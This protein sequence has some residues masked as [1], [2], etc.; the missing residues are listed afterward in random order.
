MESDAQALDRLRGYFQSLGPQALITVLIALERGILRGDDIPELQVVIAE[1]RTEIIK[2]GHK[3]PRIGNP[4]RL[5][6]QPI[7][8]FIVDWA[9]ARKQGGNIARR[10]LNPIWSWIC[11]DLAPIEAGEYIETAS[12]ALLSDDFNAS[13]KLAHAFHE[14]V[15]ARADSTFGDET[16]A[17]RAAA[18][19]TKY[20]GP[21]R[22]L[23]DL[24]ETILVLKA[25]KPLAE[26]DATLPARIEAL[27]GAQL[28]TALSLLERLT[29]AADDSLLLHAAVLI[30]KR[31]DAHWQLVRVATTA[32]QSKSPALIAATR[33]KVAVDV[34]L[35]DIE[36]LVTRHWIKFNDGAVAEAE[37]LLKAARD[38]MCGVAGELD[39][40]EDSPASRRY[41]VMP[42]AVGLS[43]ASMAAAFAKNGDNKGKS[44]A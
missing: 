33:Y 14:C 22:A 12:R 26:I 32:A 13:R 36:D 20:M 41:A 3:P 6:F 38:A 18:R 29:A 5:F 15:I 25:R 44:A 1:L 43:D 42:A 35:G 31:L 16:S 37:Q 40:S 4:S 17:A 10:S 27:E 11:R 9:P 30:M 8:P 2:S 28:D 23:A 7:E 39:L 34:V 21:P 24:R 19:L